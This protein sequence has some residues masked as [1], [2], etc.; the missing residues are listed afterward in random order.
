MGLNSDKTSEVFVLISLINQST[1]AHYR[2]VTPGQHAA[3]L[4]HVRGLDFTSSF[5]DTVQAA[6]NHFY[7]VAYGLLDK[8]YPERTITYIL[9]IEV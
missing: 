4:Q 2:R 9:F 1:R 8:F 6:L 5:P 3:F 7:N